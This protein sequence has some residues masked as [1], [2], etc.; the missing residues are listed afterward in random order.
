MCGHTYCHKCIKILIIKKKEGKYRL[1]CPEDKKTIDLEV[2][3]PKY[4]PKNIA[5]IK[6]HSKKK[7]ITGNT[8]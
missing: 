4:F 8:M 2:N 1:I 7:Q 5:L 6:A 3:N